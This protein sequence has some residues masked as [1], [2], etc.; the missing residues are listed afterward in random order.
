M[1]SVPD[2]GHRKRLSVIQAYR[3]A[4]DLS[5]TQQRALAGHAGAARTAHNWALERVKAVLDQ[6]AAVPPQGRTTDHELT[7]AP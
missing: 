4:L 6:R 3:F 1:V 5:P 7:P 2:V